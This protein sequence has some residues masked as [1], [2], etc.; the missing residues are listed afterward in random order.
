M[1]LGIYDIHAGD[2]SASDIWRSLNEIVSRSADGIK[3]PGANYARGNA[4]ADW[5]FKS[6]LTSSANHANAAI[7]H[8]ASDFVFP[9]APCLTHVR[10][11][12]ER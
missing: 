11:V 3:A 9:S 12:V 2:K 8:R 4:T 7:L 6:Q 1:K 5:P 10:H